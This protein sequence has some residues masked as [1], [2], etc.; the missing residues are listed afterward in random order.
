MVGRRRARVGEQG[1]PIDVADARP[2]ASGMPWSPHSP[3]RTGR[4]VPLTDDQAAAID[5]IRADLARPT[6]MLRLLQGDVGSG[7]TA[8]AAWALAAAAIAGRQGAL[9]APTD[10]LARQHQRTLADL[11][12][13]LGIGV[14]LLTGS[15]RA[16]RTRDRTR[17]LLAS[18]QAG[19]VVGP[20]P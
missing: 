16:A 13:P 4:P 15:L 9:L 3:R 7:K 17:D 14:E 12:A 6:P 11:L 5:A 19:V 2:L 18:G 20:T 10:L 1:R 8:V